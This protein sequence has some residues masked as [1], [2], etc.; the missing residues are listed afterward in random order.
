V[1]A[2]QPNKVLLPNSSVISRELEVLANIFENLR[3]QSSTGEGAFLN[4]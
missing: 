1:V 2:A 4:L 3:P